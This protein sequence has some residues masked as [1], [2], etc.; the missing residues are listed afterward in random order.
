MRKSVLI[1]AVVGVCLVGL[2]C[3]ISPVV[4][5]PDEGSGMYDDCRRASKDYCRDVVGASKEEMKACTSQATF[6]CLSGAGGRD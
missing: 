2:S 4:T 1:A 6:E 3:Q 5:T